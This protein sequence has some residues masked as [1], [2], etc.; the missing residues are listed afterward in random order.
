MERPSVI[1]TSEDDPPEYCDKCSDPIDYH[2]EAIMRFTGDTIDDIPVVI[3]LHPK[4]A[5]STEPT[6]PHHDTREESDGIR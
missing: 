3:F 6:E 1:I 4:C 5:Q 2:E